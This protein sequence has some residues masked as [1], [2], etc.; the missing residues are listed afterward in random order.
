[1]NGVKTVRKNIRMSEKLASFYE[2][3]ALEM[4]ISQSASMVMALDNYMRQEKSIDGVEL[5]RELNDQLLESEKQA[6]GPVK[7]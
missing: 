2:N 4:G 1:M 5:L 6:P 7:G 3:K